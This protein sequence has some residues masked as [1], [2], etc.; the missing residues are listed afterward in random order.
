MNKKML[1]AAFFSLFLFSCGRDITSNTQDTVYE[2]K[3]G[4]SFSSI[5]RDL[6]QK[7]IITDVTRFRVIAKLMRKDREMKVGIYTI[8]PNEKYRDLIIKF[9]TG[10]TQ[11]LK[12][13]IPEG[14]SIFQIA[15]LLASKGLVDSADFVERCK[16]NTYLERYNIPKGQSLEGYLYPDTYFIPLHFKSDDIIKMMLKRFDEIVD[17]KVMAKIKAKGMTLHQVL[18]MA[19]IVEKEARVQYEKPI[20]A[21]VYY[22]RLKTG[23]RLQADPTLIYALI[24]DGEYDGDIKFKH[25]RPP[26]PSPYNT[27]YIYGLPPGPIANPGKSSI[28]AAIFPADVEYVYFV[29]NPADGTHVFSKT[30]EEHNM[31]VKIYQKR[32]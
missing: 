11:F 2:I 17:D 5:A 29:A 13:T 22:R 15:E 30:L 6:K 23:M 31:N 12:L 7:G 3:K 10:K 27:Y 19:A 4:D 21:G 16:S 9:A 28:L 32:K 18:S 25:L 26:W 24:L 1:V 8:E 14:Y 20:I